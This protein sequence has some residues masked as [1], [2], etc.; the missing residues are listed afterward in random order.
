M[1]KAKKESGN[2][3]PKYVNRGS[4]L[5]QLINTAAGVLPG[6]LCIGIGFN[7]WKLPFKALRQTFALPSGITSSANIVL[8]RKAGLALGAFAY[9]FYAWAF[10][11]LTKTGSFVSDEDIK[12]KS[13]SGPR[14]PQYLPNMMYHLPYPRLA[15][16]VFDREV[17]KLA[18]ITSCAIGGK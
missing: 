1:P 18:K 10:Y 8:A 11:N 9:F 2:I 7:G 17:S 4:I 5:M 15:N 6:L 13:D 16:L 12:W 3:D 14:M